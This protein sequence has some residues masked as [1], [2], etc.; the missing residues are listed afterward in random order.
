MVTISL[1]MIVKNEEKKLDRCLS[2]IA[3][4]MDEMI[5]VD[6]GSTDK[7]KEIASK[8][9][10]KIYD[11]RWVN[12]FAAA[13]NYAFSK[14]TKEYIYSA[15]ADEVLDAENIERYRL[16]KE[17][18]LP[19]IEIVQMYYC[20]QLQF[21]SVYNY[22]KEYRPKLFKRV[23]HFTWIDPIHETIRTEPIVFDSEIEII[24]EQEESHAKRDLSAFERVCE[25]EG[26]ISPRLHNLYAR[27]LFIA[28]SED[29]FIK[30]EHFFETSCNDLEQ[31]ADEIK[32]AICVTAKA[33]RLR[34]DKLKFYKYAMRAIAS[35]GC[36]EICLELGYYHM[37]EEDLEEAVVWFYNAAFESECILDIHCGG[38]KP[39]LGIAECY[40]RLGMKELADEYEAKAREWVASA[41]IA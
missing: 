24:H 6:T 10:D 41:C 4:L 26:S 32:E 9:T 15:D 3:H 33:A 8:Y 18:L 34:G 12:D 37:E 30:A 27:E 35:D 29:D 21:G 11:F 1:C 40:H 13:R 17:C 22:D 31:S 36:A 20:N 38:D 19:E 5:I 2:G 7:T 14:A 23:R 25:K 16:L 28:G 39:L